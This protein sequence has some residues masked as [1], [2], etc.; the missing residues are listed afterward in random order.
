MAGRRIADRTFELTIAG[1]PSPGFN[2][3]VRPTATAISVGPPLEYAK[4]S[5]LLAGVSSHLERDRQQQSFRDIS[6]QAGRLRRISRS[7]RHDFVD[8]LCKPFD[9]FGAV[10]NH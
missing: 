5:L 2:P 7:L 10:E 4:Q 3:W 1:E 6:R 8:P 9:F